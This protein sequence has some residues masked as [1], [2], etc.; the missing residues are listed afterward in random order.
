MKEK[1]VT[2]S[3]ILLGGVGKKLFNNET[4]KHQII[5]GWTVFRKCLSLTISSPRRIANCRSIPAFPTDTNVVYTMLINVNKMLV[6][7]LLWMDLFMQLLKNTMA[8]FI[9]TKFDSTP[10]CRT[11]QGT[12]LEL[13]RKWNHL[14]LK[15][16]SSKQSFLEVHKVKGDSKKIIYKTLHV[17]KSIKKFT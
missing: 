1:L 10:S 2:W 17:F 5:P 8:S 12:F 16:W 14:V 6:N 4:A 13:A 15:R 9:F 3:W 11:E 7:V